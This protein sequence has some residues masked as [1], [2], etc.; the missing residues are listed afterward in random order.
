MAGRIRDED[1]ALVRE[2]SP[3][4]EVV[5][6]YVQL[7]GAGGGSLMGLCPFHE[8]KTPSFHV[9]PARGLWYC[10]GGCS[11]GGDVIAF[12]QK[13]EQL[14]FAEAIERLARRAGVELRYEEGGYTPGRQQSERSRLVEAHREAAAFYAG[15][16]GSADAQPA[17]R[18]LAERGF[19]RPDAERFGVGYAPRS[20]DALVRHLRACGFTDHEL[21]KGGLARQGRRGLLDRFRGR[22]LWPVRDVSGEVVGFGARRLYDDDPIEAK[23]LNTPETVIYKKSST[24]YAVDLA[25]K[26]I[27]R[28]QRAVVV[29]GYTDVMACHLAGVST[30]VATCGTSFGDGHIKILRRLLMDQSEFRGEVIFTFDGDDAGR[31]AALRVFE[32][33]RQFVTQTFVAVQA[34]GLDPCDLRIRRGDGAVRDLVA[35]RV[36]LFEFAIR[37]VLDRYDL[38]I[39]E[40]RVGA[41]RKAAPMIASIRDRSLRPEYVRVAAG[42]LGMEVEAVASAVREAGQPGSEQVTA[43]RAPQR[44]RARLPDSTDPAIQV[45]REALKIV[46]QRPAL[47]G[48]DFDG[49]DPSV[50]TRPEHAAAQQAVTAAGGAAAGVAGGAWVASVLDHAGDEAVRALVT[51]LA[52]E[53]PRSVGE[54]DDTY[55]RAVLSRVEELAATRAI[56]ET[57]S[58]LRRLSPV[59][60]PQ[61]YNRLFGD[62]VALEQQ[63]R[64][65]RERAIGAL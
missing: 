62:L 14:S 8:E 26:E 10:F 37:S 52:V 63:R 32:D 46:I 60:R 28:S 7:R 39:P 5:G 56:A 47:A 54:I 4:E 44:A 23:Y 40:G 61:E 51:E 36:P 38:E 25:K 58:R 42:W 21:V 59:E 33:E 9:T 41:L 35:R 16:L 49:L 13:V 15:Q 11:E 1:I 57:K 65:L 22:L 18:F 64:A 55:V 17:R 3:I 12:V 29:E 27:A 48:P 20:W 34:E 43:P 24:L 19:E 50:F 45:E 53:P 30:A 2:R 6:D 31:R